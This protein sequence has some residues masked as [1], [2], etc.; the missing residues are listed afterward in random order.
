MKNSAQYIET[1][2]KKEGYSFNLF[3]KLKERLTDYLIKK[4]LFDN[5][6]LDR[7]K[8][9]FENNPERIEI[10]KK[11]NSESIGYIKIEYKDSNL[12]YTFTIIG[13]STEKQVTSTK[14]FKSYKTLI[15]H[16]DQ[17]KNYIKGKSYEK[18]SQ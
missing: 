13:I 18:C 4:Y 14:T 11:G 12:F 7:F 6:E 1:E 2:L 3:N 16:L 10:Y 15:K 17:Y 8:L 9:N 5:N